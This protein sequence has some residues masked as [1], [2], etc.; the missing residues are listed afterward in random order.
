MRARGTR[1]TRRAAPAPRDLALA[2]AGLALLIPSQLLGQGQPPSLEVGEASRCAVA[3]PYRSEGGLIV[4]PL[5]L[6]GMRGF[7]LALDTGTNISALYSSEVASAL[8]IRLD[9]PALARGF[10]SGSVEVTLS[11]PVQIAGGGVD[12]VEAQ[13]AVHDMA[14]LPRLG[15]DLEIHGLIGWEL[16]AR[17]MVE[18]DPR[19]GIVTLH[20]RPH[21][22]PPP[23]TRQLELEII[24][25]RPIVK[26]RVTTEE[27]KRVKVRL[28]VDTGSGSLI[29]LVIDSS[30]HLRL[31]AEA[32][33]VRVL[34]VGGATV[35][36]AGALRE[37]ELGGLKISSPQA[38]FVPRY[39]LPASLRIPRLNGVLGNR[40]LQMHH[41]WIDL[42]GAR[43]SLRPLTPP[44][45][46]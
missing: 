29:S 16:L 3:I 33:Q 27:G 8:G 34:G 21:P 28:L 30:R 38:T 26:A 2:L 5:S 23:D 10:G 20:P 43:L 40:F 45:G 36:H 6:E 4:L 19:A 35:A 1:E 12:L 22:E 46:S 18:I 11:S 9:R 15:Q 39:K 25:N 7:N 14:R 24:D 44:E 31:P 37:L 42:R 41:V 32:R 17:W 13:M